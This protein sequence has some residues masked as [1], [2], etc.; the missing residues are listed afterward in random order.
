[1]AQLLELTGSVLTAKCHIQLG[2][3]Q[4]IKLKL[5]AKLGQHTAAKTREGAELFV[6]LS[7]A[8][9]DQMR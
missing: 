1:M 3:T 7:L 5:R 4:M 8:G 6:Q 2:M 9:S